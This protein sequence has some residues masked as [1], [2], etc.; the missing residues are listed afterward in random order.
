MQRIRKVCILSIPEKS[1][2]VK[3]RKVR[4]LER[5]KTAERSETG[6]LGDQQTKRGEA[7][8]QGEALATADRRETANCK[9]VER[10]VQIKEDRRL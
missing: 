9:A 4:K 5:L 8:R 1:E 10:S 3:G 6:R 7:K 2:W